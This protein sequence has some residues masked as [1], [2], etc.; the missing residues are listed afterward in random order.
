MARIIIRKAKPQ[1]AEKMTQIAMRSKA[2]WGYSDELLSLWKEDLKVTPEFL[3]SAIGYVVECD[4]VMIG[5]WVREAIQAD[6]LTQGFLFI[7]PEFIGSGC[8][9]LLFDA[10][11]N[12]M[13]ERGIH[14][15][16]F[17][18][19]PNAAGFYLKMG[20]VK[21]GEKESKVVKGRKLPIIKIQL[22]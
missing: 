6:Q 4:D 3:K 16:T 1:D 19:D 17:E 18:A 20:G 7:E 10:L 12:G 14:S 2:H 21:I 13:Q 9:R 8:G 22:D 5:Y 11:K 15:F